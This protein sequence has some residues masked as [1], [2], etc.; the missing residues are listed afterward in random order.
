MDDN[1]RKVEPMDSAR[2]NS[3][4]SASLDSEATLILDASK[5]Q[6]YWNDS[7]FPEG[8]RVC[9]SGVTYECQMGHWVKLHISC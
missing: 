6:C 2:K 7:E 9:N 5:Y 1:I 8:T 4:V 3:E